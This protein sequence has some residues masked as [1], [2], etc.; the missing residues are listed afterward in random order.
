LKVTTTFADGQRKDDAHFLRQGIIKEI[1]GSNLKG[2]KGSRYFMEK[3]DSV[4]PPTLR[5]FSFLQ[6]NGLGN[7]R[8]VAQTLPKVEL[9]KALDPAVSE[10]M[11]TH[12]LRHMQNVPLPVNHGVCQYLRIMSKMSDG[13]ISACVSL[14]A[15]W[16]SQDTQDWIHARSRHPR[17]GV[18]NLPHQEQEA[19]DLK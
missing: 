12:A 4:G 6:L 3:M 11:L 7:R 14:R 5:A 9:W 16:R 8:K 18:D 13:R 2:K 17:L 19:Q 10:V 1:E 15:G